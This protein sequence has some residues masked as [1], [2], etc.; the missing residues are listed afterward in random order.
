MGSAFRASESRSHRTGVCTRLTEW[1]SDHWPSAP[2]RSRLEFPFSY[3]ARRAA[4]NVQSVPDASGLA[5]APTFSTPPSPTRRSSSR[6]FRWPW[7]LAACSASPYVSRVPPLR[8]RLFVLRVPSPYHAQPRPTCTAAAPVVPLSHTHQLCTHPTNCILIANV[9][10]AAFRAPIHSLSNLVHRSTH[11]WACAPYGGE[12]TRRFR[13]GRSGGRPV[14]SRLG[15]AAQARPCQ[16][17]S[18]GIQS[19]CAH[20]PAIPSNS[21]H[22]CGSPM[23]AP[24]ALITHSQNG[25]AH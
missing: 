13:L 22:R 1:R 9:R 7:R 8:V 23:I 10:D 5:C 18:A 11:G 12:S 15:P 16:P 2:A 4:V 19:V 17:A 24:A 20:P 25:E 14:V 21:A 3:F 6:R